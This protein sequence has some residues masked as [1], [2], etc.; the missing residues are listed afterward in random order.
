MFESS[1]VA[2]GQGRAL[3]RC[4]RN[5]APQPHA[6]VGLPRLGLGLRLTSGLGS[7][8]GLGLGLRL[9]LGLGLELD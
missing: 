3:L 2:C 5:H 6:Q 8:L 4:N 1:L 7:G 9:G